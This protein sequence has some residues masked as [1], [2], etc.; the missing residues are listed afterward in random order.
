M[1]EM[2]SLG[3]NTCMMAE[4]IPTLALSWALSLSGPQALITPLGV[5]EPTLPDWDSATFHS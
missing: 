5:P 1:G 3:A 4:R 2:E